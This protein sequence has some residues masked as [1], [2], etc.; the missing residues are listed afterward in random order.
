MMIE[1]IVKEAGETQG[2]IVHRLPFVVVVVVVVRFPLSPSLDNRAR[3]KALFS[4]VSYDVVI[5]SPVQYYYLCL[6]FLYAAPPT[7]TTSFENSKSDGQLLARNWLFFAQLPLRFLRS[8]RLRV[9]I[10]GRC[11]CVRESA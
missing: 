8:R 1:G 11:V 9:M 2:C 7:S 6:T 10:A 5:L 4:L 3:S